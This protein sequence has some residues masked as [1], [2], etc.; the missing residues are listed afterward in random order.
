[1]D[2]KVQSQPEPPPFRPAQTQ[3]PPGAPAR[4]PQPIRVL[5]YRWYRMGGYSNPSKP[6]DLMPLRQ[7]RVGGLRFYVQPLG[8]PDDSSSEHGSS[9]TTNITCTMS[10]SLP[11]SVISPLQPDSE[12][13]ERHWS[14]ETTRGCTPLTITKRRASHTNMPAQYIASLKLCRSLDVSYTSSRSGN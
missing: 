9:W 6:L 4:Y 13:P 5:P 12:D 10:V 1:M 14:V 2:M 3:R 11:L 8:L 7:A